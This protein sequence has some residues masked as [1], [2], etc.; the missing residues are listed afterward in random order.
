MDAVAGWAMTG[1]SCSIEAF[2][3]MISPEGRGL[4]TELTGDSPSDRG[5]RS[6]A[7]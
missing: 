5:V 3:T 6:T 7:S 1:A 4:T 2:D